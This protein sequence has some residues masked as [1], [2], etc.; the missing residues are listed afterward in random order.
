MQARGRARPP[1]GTRMLDHPAVGWTLVAVGAFATLAQIVTVL[2]VERSPAGLSWVAQTAVSVAV[3][4]AVLLRRANHPLAGWLAAA[5]ALGAVG[6]CLDSLLAWLGREGGGAGAVAALNLGLQEATLVAIVAMVHVIGLFADGRIQR[7]YERTV[8]STTWFVLLV[9]LLLMLAVPQVTLPWYHATG[10][11]DSPLFVP[12]VAVDPAVGRALVDLVFPTLF[13]VGVLLFGLRYRRGDADSRRPMRWLLVPVVFSVVVAVTN[14]LILV[15][16]PIWLINLLWILT[17]V[18]MWVSIGLGI[19]RPRG[20]DIDRVVRKSLVY[21]VLW[22][23]I[24][25]VYV[26]IGAAVGVYAGQL[27]PIEWAATAAVVA[28][29]AFQPARTRLELL[30]DRWVF[31][32]PTDPARAVERLG[33]ALA[34]T[35]DVDELLP[36][37]AD[38]VAEGLDLRWVR[39][40]LEPEDVR[41][42]D[43]DGRGEPA[44]TVPITLEGEEVGAIECGPSRGGRFDDDDLAVLHTFARQAALAVSNVRLTRRLEAQARQL[45]AS[46]ARLVRAQALERRRI[47]RNIHDGVQQELVALIGLAGQARAA[48]D[49]ALPGEE[50][51]ELQSGL[52]R[53]LTDLRELAQGIHP[54]VLSDKGLLEA[55]ESLAARHPVPVTVR[56]EAALRGLRLPEDVEG[57]GYFTVAESLANSLKHAD[58]A[59]VDVELSRT[60]TALL[61]RIRDDGVGLDPQAQSGNGLS[62]LSERLAAVGGRLE[63][64]GRPGRGTVVAAAIALAEGGGDG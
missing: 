2:V 62:N 47:E 44:V 35:Y 33:S 20:L 50:L 27:L 16:E 59:R 11:V 49:E 8:L 36:A 54:S 3:A 64:S 55:V 46:R 40:R 13:L 34:E 57:A 9:P 45:A 29:I 30:A 12:A 51:D 48:C 38:T 1:V 5:A 4:A 15:D 19:V 25:L 39:V 52:Q 22:L 28:A 23:A 18:L 24:A 63:V 10:P 31:G 41:A 61:I 60:K 32:A 7:R 17:G 14:L 58:A 56:S 21:S 42:G 43:G 53:V 6:Q 26:A 37:I